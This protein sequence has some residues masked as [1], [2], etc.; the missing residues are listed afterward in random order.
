MRVGGFG[1]TDVGKKR[2]HNED[3]VLLAPELGLFMVCDGMGGHAAGEVASELA[4]R[5]VRKHIEEKRKIID[6]YDES[7]PARDQ[8]LKLV[9]EA[10]QLASREVYSLATSESGK[11]GM[12]TTLTMILVLK[13]VGVMG[14]VGDTRLYMRRAGRLHQ[15]SEDHT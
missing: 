1:R 9:E 11:A 4:A 8:I 6:G 13:T 12:G 15:L 10:V 3:Y 2:G 5:T 7:A 14:H